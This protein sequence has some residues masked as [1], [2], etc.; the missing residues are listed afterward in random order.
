MS[1][2]DRFN[3]VESSAYWSLR[4]AMTFLL[5]L[6]I[7]SLSGEETGNE[8]SDSFVMIFLLLMVVSRNNQLHTF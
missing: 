7:G 1:D 5:R 8:G 4:A 2:D 6:K 3:T